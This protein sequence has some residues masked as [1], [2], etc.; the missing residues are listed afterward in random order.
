MTSFGDCFHAEHRDRTW[1][2]FRSQVKRRVGL[3]RSLASDEH[4]F[5]PGNR[6]L[7]DTSCKKIPK[8]VTCLRYFGHHQ[9]TQPLEWNIRAENLQDILRTYLF[10]DC[11]CCAPRR[12]Q[13]DILHHRDI[14]QLP[15]S[16]FLTPPNARIFSTC[17]APRLYPLDELYPPIGTVDVRN[18]LRSVCNRKAIKL[19]RKSEKVSECE[20]V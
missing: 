14:Q 19:V 18:E 9:T 6:L 3:S 4:P 16:S 15:V 11:H 5:R 7:S 10:A 1:T 8:P 13:R 20:F 12:S 17:D 2:Y